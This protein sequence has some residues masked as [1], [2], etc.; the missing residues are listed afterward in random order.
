VTS[1]RRLADE[2]AVRGGDGGAVTATDDDDVRSDV[3][4]PEE[5][6]VEAPVEDADEP[7][8]EDAAE[9]DDEAP[10]RRRRRRRSRVDDDDGDGGDGGGRTR[11]S[12][13]LV[14]ALVILLVV[15]LGGVGYLW[16][17]R[18]AKSSVETA[19]YVEA[20]Q[21]ARSAVV[22]LTSFDYLTLDDDIEQ[23]RR[24]TTGDLRDEAIKQ[25]D[26]NRDTI[27]KT[28]STVNTEIVAAA[29][30]AADATHATVLLV[31]QSTQE[32]KTN[33]QGQVT[34]YRIQA[35]LEKVKGRWLLS[36]IAGR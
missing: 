5:E 7:D 1:D 22:D 25:L 29:V 20:L 21:A 32:N 8:G 36:G 26:D 27:T 18:P 35:T 4:A 13:P 17:T 28:E 6:A 2:R 23:I 16:F 34:K 31:I 33:K 10:A 19:H 14:P 12:F 24:I 3:A 9:A 30:T 15:L 11:V